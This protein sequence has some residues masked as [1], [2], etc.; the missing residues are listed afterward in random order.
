MAPPARLERAAAERTSNTT[1]TTTTT[2]ASTTTTTAATAAGRR[3]RVHSRSR[4]R[5]WVNEFS[6]PRRSDDV[7]GEPERAAN[8]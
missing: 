6:F 5:A 8:A 1:T 2:T 7:L 4:R 3:L